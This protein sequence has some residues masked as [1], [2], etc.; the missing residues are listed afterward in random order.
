M[1][2]EIRTVTPDEWEKKHGRKAKPI[3]ETLLAVLRAAY[4]DKQYRS[5]VVPDDEVEELKKELG[6]ASKK[7]NVTCTKQVQEDQPGYKKIIFKVTNRVLRP[8]KEIWNGNV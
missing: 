4:S 3:P 5:I 7:L 1:A 6:R 8:R 2:Y